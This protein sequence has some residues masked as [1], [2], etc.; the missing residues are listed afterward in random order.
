MSV[1][2]EENARFIHKTVRSCLH[3]VEIQIGREN[4]K[5]KPFLRRKEVNKDE[6]TF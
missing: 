5:R 2:G 1:D 6:M 4:T 3:A